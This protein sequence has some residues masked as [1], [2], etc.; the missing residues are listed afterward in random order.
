MN[1]SCYNVGKT[2]ENGQPPLS[3][4]LPDRRNPPNYPSYFPLF[5]TSIEGG[6]RQEGSP[7]FKKIG[8]AVKGPEPRVSKAFTKIAI[9]TSPITPEEKNNSLHLLNHEITYFLALIM[10]FKAN[11]ERLISSLERMATYYNRLL[12]EM[13]LT[14]HIPKDQLNRILNST[15]FNGEDQQDT[16]NFLK[17][18]DSTLTTSLILKSLQTSKPDQGAPKNAAFIYQILQCGLILSMIKVAGTYIPSTVS[19]DLKRNLIGKYIKT[20]ISQLSY[21]QKIVL[22]G[23]WLNTQNKI[24]GHFM[25]YVLEKKDSST[26]LKARINTHAFSTTADENSPHYSVEEEII[27]ASNIDEFIYDLLELLFPQSLNE[28][29]SAFAPEKQLGALY[30]TGKNYSNST[31]TLPEIANLSSQDGSYNCCFTAYFM[32]YQYLYKRKS[33]NSTTEEIDQTT[34]KALDFRRQFQEFL[35]ATLNQMNSKPN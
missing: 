1:D 6:N 14:N 19:E 23:G 17:A 15:Y 25:L 31:P 8:K 29:I 13:Y 7:R 3:V 12:N 24:E 2:I 21:D 11:E 10:G 33:P 35:Q 34:H 22:P 5:K 18:P 4:P 28:K 27:S 20:Q 9:P 30:K 16:T 26:F 32:L